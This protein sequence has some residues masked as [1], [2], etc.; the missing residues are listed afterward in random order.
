MSDLREE[1][2]TISGIGPAK[3]KEIINIVE[4]H[5]T[6]DELAE[7]VRQAWDYYDDGQ[8]RYAGKYLKRA[9]AYLED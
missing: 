2:Q 9:V 7:Q 5:N 1:L 6:D 8:R 4:E 3:A